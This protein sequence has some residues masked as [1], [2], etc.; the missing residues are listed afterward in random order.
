MNLF[1]GGLFLQQALGWTNIYVCIVALLVLTALCSAMGGLA[2]VIYT[3]TVQF[4]VMIGGSA[5]L[6]Y[7]G[8]NNLVLQLVF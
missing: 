1:S 4:F 2:A 7:K 3:D 6:A 5:I 8:G